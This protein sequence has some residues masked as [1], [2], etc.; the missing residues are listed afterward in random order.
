MGFQ[1]GR[2][3]ELI[4]RLISSAFLIPLA[5]YAVTSGGVALAVGCALVAG[6]MAYEWVRMTASP[7]LKWMVSFALL[8]CLAVPVMGLFPSVLV[9]LALSTLAGYTH[10]VRK[11]QANAT[12]GFLYV[13]GM[14]LGLLWLREGPWD[15][16]IAALL[17]MGIVWGS[18]SAAYFVGRHFGG[19]SLTPESPSKTW[20]GAV[21]GVVFSIL[22]GALGAYIADG[23]LVFWL[24][25][26][27]GISVI[28]QLGDLMESIIKRRHGI[29]DTSKLLPGHGGVM[30]RVDGLGMVCLVAPVL[31]LLSP[32]TLAYLGLM[33]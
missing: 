8:P 15:G 26:G 19:P 16:Q 7:A 9:L 29:K 1:S 3:N 27:A 17:I 33:A 14:P 13:A 32:A 31:F 22:C 11:E 5:L 21:G 4:L 25:F 18:D 2:P 24:A 20:S 23:D 30:D 28:A 6:L 10:P 12:L